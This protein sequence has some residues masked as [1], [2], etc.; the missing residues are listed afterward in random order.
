MHDLHGQVAMRG[1]TPSAN[2]LHACR[3]QRVGSTSK[4]FHTSLSLYIYIYDWGSYADQS[5]ASPRDERCGQ[6]PARLVV[7]A[8]R[9]V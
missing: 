8:A 1:S 9:S 3:I 7:M 5:S 6:A 2:R 4:T